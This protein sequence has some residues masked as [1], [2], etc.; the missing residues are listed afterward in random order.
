MTW[1]DFYLG[2]FVVG[3]ALTLISLLGG[4]HLHIPHLHLHVHLPHVHVPD[5][6]APHVG[7]GDVPVFNFGTLAAFLVW[8]GATGYLLVRFSSLWAFFSLGIAGAA[9]LLGGAIIFLFLA[10][11][12]MRKEENLDPAD[13]EMVGVLGRLSLPIRKGGTGEIV[14]TQAGTRHCAGARSEVGAEIPKGAEVVVTR[15]EKGIAYVERWEDLA[16]ADAIER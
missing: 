11:V 2:C 8:F 13:Y 1:A 15:Y 16:G 10:K 5:V 4:A 7:A 6:H 3:F 12:L 9:G 14:F